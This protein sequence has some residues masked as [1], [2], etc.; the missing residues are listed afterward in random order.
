MPTMRRPVL[1]HQTRRAD[2]PLVLAANG[3]EHSPPPATL[4][5]HNTTTLM[6]SARRNGT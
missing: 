2:A 3:S 4:L 6:L 1:R 5:C